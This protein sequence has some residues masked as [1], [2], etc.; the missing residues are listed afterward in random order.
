MQEGYSWNVF[1]HDLFAGMSVG[2]I[3]LPLALAFAIASG[4][5]PEKG[6]FTAIVA[7][8]LISFLGGSRVQIGGPTGAFVVIIYAVIQKFG[9][10]GLALATL[11]AAFLMIAMGLARFGVLLKFIPYP[12]TV[13]FTTGIAVVIFS[14]QVKDFFGLQI[15]NVP[16]E[17]LEKCKIFCQFAHTW[18]VWA[19]IISSFT[20]ILIFL[21]RRFYPKLPGTILAVSLA[22]LLAQVFQLPLISI[23]D[24]FGEIPRFLPEPALPHFSYDLLK[25]V[26]PDAITIALLGAIESLLSAVV[27]DGITGHRHRSNCELVAQG[28]AN[29]GSILFGGIPATGAIA[30]TNANIRLG[31]KTPVAGMVHAVTLLCI[32]IFCAPLAGKIPL[33]ALSA[34]LI[35]VAWNMSELPHFFEIMKGQFGDSVVLVITFLLTVLID[36]AVAVQIGVILAAVIFLKRMTDRTT[37]EACKILIEENNHEKPDRHD[38]DLLKAGTS[39]DVVVFEIKGP[40]FYSVS[41]LLDETLLRL[42]DVPRVFIL[43]LNQTPLIDATGIR[44]I[45]QFSKKC[46]SK[47]IDFR[48]SGANAHQI[49]LLKK[50]GID[51]RSFSS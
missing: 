37:I 15:D 16:P 35:F 12:V 26:F 28:L 19:L 17:F 7:G 27:A 44:A 42:D 43:R 14:S 5:P 10:D 22:T 39:S 50:G 8:F 38:D 9:Y 47:G 51:D 25:A 2:V 41:D 23:E 6:L 49:R 36:L 11:I 24:K 29:I 21:L 1:S 48:I 46:E 4:V 40:F 30:R 33:A 31:A 18:N 34:V 13:G 3:A 20:L 45:K 32:M